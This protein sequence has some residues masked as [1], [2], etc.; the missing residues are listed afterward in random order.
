M[1]ANPKSI[2]FRLPSKPTA[3]E[4]AIQAA[5]PETIE[6]VAVVE[7]RRAHITELVPA[8]LRHDMIAVA[9][10]HRSADRGFAPG[11]ELEDWLAAESEVDA[12]LRA[13][14]AW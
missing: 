3:V 8:S 7:H 1:A 6:A 5:G 13:R 12:T 2:R 14:Y 11:H 10:Y 9:A 4:P